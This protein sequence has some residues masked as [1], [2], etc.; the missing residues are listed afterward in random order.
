MI[1]EGKSDVGAYEAWK[2]RVREDLKYRTLLSG[3]KRTSKKFREYLQTQTNAAFDLIYFIVDRDYDD[4]GS[5][6]I[7]ENMF[8]T[9]RYSIENYFVSES[10]LESILLDEFEC[11][12]D[13][14]EVKAALQ[15]FESVTAQFCDAMS[16]VNFR[17]FLAAKYQISKESVGEKCSP[18]VTVHIDHVEKICDACSI[19]ALVKLER[20]PTE[21]ELAEGMAEFEKL[22][23]PISDHRGKYLLSFFLSWLDLLSQARR[24]GKICFSEKKTFKYSRASLTFRSLAIRSEMPKQIDEFINS[25]AS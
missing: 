11:H 19:Q 25:I 7:S 10:V 14:E 16:E 9:D 15:L 24:E 22:G 20:E 18:F 3:G 12:E 1:F 6:A 4:I 13:H 2:S 23:D 21:E 8:C 17:L 5:G